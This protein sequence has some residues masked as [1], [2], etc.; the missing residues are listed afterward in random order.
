M[1]RGIFYCLIF[2][3]AISLFNCNSGKDSFSNEMKIDSVQFYLNKATN[4]SRDSNVYFEKALEFN[5]KNK[6]DSVRIKNGLKISYKALKANDSIHFVK[7]NNQ[8]QNLAKKLNDS[9]ALAE[10]FWN[11][12]SFYYRINEVDSS[13]YYYQRAYK[14]YAKKDKEY[15]E[16]KMLYNMA[17][18]QGRIKDYLGCENNL[19]KAIE[20]YKEKN[21]YKSLYKS[22]NLLGN[23]YLEVEDYENA[24]NYHLESL[25][26]LNKIKDEGNFRIGTLNDIGVTHKTFGK[27]NKAIISFKEALAEKNLEKSDSAIYA[28][29]LDNLGHTYYLK[30][31]YNDSIQLFLEKAHF[32]RE[33][34]NNKQGLVVSKMHLAE[35]YLVKKDTLKALNFSTEAKNLAKE[36]NNNREVL[37]SLALMGNVDKANASKHLNDYIQVSNELQNYERNL[38]NTVAK[39]QFETA[40]QI[41]KNEKLSNQK[42]ILIVAIGIVILFLILLA[43]FMRQNIQNRT[44]EFQHKQRDANEKIYALMLKQQSRLEEGRIRERKR[45]SEELHDGILG[46]IFGTR[47]SLGFL[48]VGNDEYIRNKLNK[49]ANELQE[50]E[51][52]IRTISHDLRNENFATGSD[53]RHFIK[54]FLD[55]QSEVGNF[56][57]TLNIDYHIDWDV[58]DKKIM[59][60]F[61][62]IIQEA[63]QNIIKH[64]DAKKIYIDIRLQEEN[65]SLKITDDGIGMPL[66]KNK[67]KKG[68]GILNMKSRIE[69]L[70]GSIEIISSKLSGTTIYI[71]CP[72]LV[73]EN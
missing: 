61:Y 65:L 43:L 23:L 52:E 73:E 8:A 58:L 36:L 12:G 15:Y 37:S 7:A 49:Y 29:V 50:I 45:I 27:Y 5:R 19:F 28:R 70:K 64:A 22:Y 30:G 26:N 32:I 44:L 2:F 21:K 66:N 14:I 47:M 9:I 68:I 35:F 71:Q 42:S 41:E 57:Y 34:L 69:A 51:K 4:D 24:L 54:S 63:V 3:I 38:K 25:E 56:N 31:N 67:R 48:K 33:K 46:K 40:E 17:F 60:N 10:T 62:R 11:K 39:I 59:V 6:I 20:I 18:I 53:F 1:N 16:A 13:Y 55:D 72:V